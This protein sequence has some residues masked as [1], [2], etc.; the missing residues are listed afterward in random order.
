M[1]P[2]RQQIRGRPSRF[3][4][5]LG[6][7]PPPRQAPLEAR[8]VAPIPSGASLEITSLRATLSALKD[9][10]VRLL[11]TAITAIFYTFMKKHRASHFRQSTLTTKATLFIT[12]SRP[13]ILRPPYFCQRHRSLAL[14]SG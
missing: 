11:L 6:S 8:S 9:V 2:L 13:P 10:K 5:G 3:W 12:R 7:V 14:A 4:K 1:R